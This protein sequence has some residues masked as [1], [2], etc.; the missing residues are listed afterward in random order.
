[1]TEIEHARTFSFDQLRDTVT[2]ESDQPVLVDFWEPRCTACRATLDTID[3]L[4]CRIDG[5]GIVGTFNVRNNPEAAR[6]LGVKTVPTLIV[7]RSGKVSSVLQG[8]KHIQDFVE[9]ID[10]EVFL[11]NPPPCEH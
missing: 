1:M 10:E 11:G 2:S 5:Y 7:F 6:S 4:A 3:D 9:R 8:A